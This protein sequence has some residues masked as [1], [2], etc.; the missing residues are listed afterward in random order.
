MSP[1]YRQKVLKKLW[2]LIFG[3]HGLQKYYKIFILLVV[4]LLFIF[5]TDSKYKDD[6]SLYLL[7]HETYNSSMSTFSFISELA[8]D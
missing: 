6:V 2:E 7:N 1:I 4:V 5:R 3:I 8:G